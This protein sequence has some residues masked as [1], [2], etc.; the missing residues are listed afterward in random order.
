MKTADT[1]HGILGAILGRFGSVTSGSQ[2][3]FRYRRT[4]TA[5]DLLTGSALAEEAYFAEQPADNENAK[6]VVVSRLVERA[7]ENQQY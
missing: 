1:R 5:A 2:K 3:I 7:K 4:G 6:C